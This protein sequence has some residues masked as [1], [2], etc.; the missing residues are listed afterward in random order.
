MWRQIR[1]PRCRPLLL[2]APRPPR[3]VQRGGRVFFRNRR[4]NTMRRTIRRRARHRV[5]ICRAFR[6]SV[7]IVESE[8]VVTDRRQ[9]FWRVA[10]RCPAFARYF[11][12]E[13]TPAWPTWGRG[14]FIPTSATAKCGLLRTA[15]A[16]SAM[17]AP[18]SKTKMKDDLASRFQMSA[19]PTV[20]PSAAN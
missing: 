14:R 19:A 15:S 18:F 10:T 17:S 8:H 11:L 13:T 1:D 5:T 4:E 7:Q 9:V 12:H 16:P 2:F 3:P 6:H 20:S